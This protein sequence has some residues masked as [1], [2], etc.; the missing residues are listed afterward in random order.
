MK[1]QRF[2]IVRSDGEM[3]IMKRASGLSWDEVAFRVTVN[4]PEG[5]GRV[6][7]DIEITM[8]EPPTEAVISEFKTNA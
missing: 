4:I 1:F 3:R 6:R 2:L 5:W 8:P 7:G